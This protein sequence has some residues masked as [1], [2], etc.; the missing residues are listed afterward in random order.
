MLPDSWVVGSKVTVTVERPHGPKQREE[1]PVLQRTAPV[2]E[3]EVSL[4][5]FPERQHTRRYR[6]HTGSLPM[7][8]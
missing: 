2:V 5:A 3:A 1:N 6:A 4:R 8:E 7:A